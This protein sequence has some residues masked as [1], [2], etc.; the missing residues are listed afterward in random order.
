MM[1][2][3]TGLSS[4]IRAR[5]FKTKIGY[6]VTLGRQKDLD[7]KRVSPRLDLW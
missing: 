6:I 2:C 1:V 3:P 4:G 5:S 7:Q